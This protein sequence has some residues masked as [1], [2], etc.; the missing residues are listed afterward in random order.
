MKCTNAITHRPYLP[1]GQK[2]D[3]PYI[4]RLAPS[5]NAIMLEWLD[6]ASSDAYTL[7]FRVR[8]TEEWEPFPIPSKT[9]T[10][11]GLLPNTDYELYV[12]NAEGKH[13]RIRL[14]RT[15]AIPE[16]TSVI[17]YLHPEDEQYLFSGKHLCS[18]SIVK[19]GS[20]RLIAGMDVFGPAMGQN[21]TLLFSSDDKG[22]SWHYLCDLYPFYWSCLFY[23]QDAIFL[24][25]VTTEYGNL[26]IS[27]STDDGVTW[28]A[29]CTILYGA[30]VLCATGGI[31]REPMH[32]TEYHGR[33]YTGLSIGSWKIGG[34]DPAVLSIATDADPMLAESWTLSDP[35]PFEGKWKDEAGKRGDAIEGNFVVAPDGK[36]YDYMR[37]KRGE[38]LKLRVNTD[39]LDVAP[40]YVSI[41]PAPVSNSMFRIF[42]H[43]GKYYL[44]T[45]RK[46]RTHGDYLRN[47]LSLYES[48][49][50]KSFRFLRDIV[51]M[52]DEDPRQFGFQYP[53]FSLDGNT[54][55]VTIRSAFNNADSFHNS[56]YI[57]FY[58]TEL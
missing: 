2:L 54:L 56:N 25:G 41:E 14:A 38:M 7:F 31:S 4:C 36:L 6:T 53:A 21:T 55:Y 37:W 51:N 48:N 58:K 28:E 35:L 11:N 23:H 19:T 43:N 3:G 45:N 27:R 12:E 20:G 18:P 22:E 52:E 1:P 8:G 34:H 40:E 16:G 10:V 46:S 29:P 39:Q 47:V 9:F 32:L 33:L 49:D 5:E 44:L 50:L 42:F 17:N 30:N 15:G 24:L 57:L 26:Q 13:S